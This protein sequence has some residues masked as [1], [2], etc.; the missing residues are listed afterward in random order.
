MS[1]LVVPVANATDRVWLGAASGNWNTPGNWSP[2]GVPGAGDNAFVTNNGTYTVTL[3]AASTASSVTVGGASGTQTLNLDRF[4]LTLGSPSVIN[5]NG[6]I[7]MPNNCSIAGAGNLNVNGTLNWANGA[8]NGTGVITVGSGG[9][10]AVGPN[11][12]T[13]LPAVL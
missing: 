13:C 12:V 6:H 5:A 10:L 2:S 4:V 7:D 3:S 1:L 8:L 9:V 11:N